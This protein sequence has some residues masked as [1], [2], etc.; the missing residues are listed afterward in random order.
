[1]IPADKVREVADGLVEKWL[2]DNL[3]VYDRTEAAV[4]AG[5]QYMREQ[6][7]QEC[8]N[9][10]SGGCYCEYCETCEHCAKA[11]RAIRI[12]GEQT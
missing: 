10:R 3:D 9:Q 6:A 12:E 4:I 2:R 1:M 8:S 5:M 7:A 11:I